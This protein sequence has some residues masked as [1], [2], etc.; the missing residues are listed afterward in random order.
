M[1]FIWKIQREECKKEK[2]IKNIATMG[3]NINIVLPCV[4]Y[5]DTIIVQ[6]KYE[7]NNSS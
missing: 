5:Y 7:Y 3:N 6:Y 4:Y 2:T 1:P